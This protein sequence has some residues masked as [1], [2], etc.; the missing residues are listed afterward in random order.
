VRIFFERI[1]LLITMKMKP[2]KQKSV[3]LQVL[4]GGG[5]GRES[6]GRPSG[7]SIGITK[8]PLFFFL[9]FLALLLL[10]QIVGG[11]VW[12]FFSQNTAKTTLTRE[13][14]LELTHTVSGIVTFDEEIILAPRSGYVYYLTEDGMRAPVGA[15]LAMISPLPLEEF[16]PALQEDEEGV[17][18]YL[19]RFKGWLA[20]GGSEE[21]DRYL[22]LFLN[23]KESTIYNRQAGLISFKLDGWEEYGPKTAFP[24]FT[25]EEFAGRVYVDKLM[26][27][28]EQ[29][30]IHS[31]LLRVIDN[32]TWFYSVVLP[33]SPGESFSE[34]YEIAIYFAF[35]PEQRLTGAL[36]KVRR[37][38]D[39]WELTWEMDR[40]V[41]DFH[42]QR[43]SDAEIV[44]ETVTGVSVPRDSLLEI[45]GQKGVYIIE[46]GF[47][48]FRPI[49]ILGENED[50]YLAE[51]LEAYEEI[52]L[53][54]E[55]VNDG[56]RFYW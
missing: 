41:D 34:K 27:N 56:Q 17:E 4:K 24:Y 3:D 8:R 7:R 51:N 25:E 23:N 20:R 49:R 38:L 28:G 14:S 42:N 13:G 6:G 37:D 16:I 55:K 35:A 31:P 53:E 43:W 15:E 12:G 32:Y 36:I 26:T 10:L 30:N 47:V 54:P 1:R 45:D 11:W 40:F 29:V 5:G 48:T 21:D 52:V 18:K 39:K 33:A 19:A 50:F 22:T 2:S 9:P 46:K 44:Y